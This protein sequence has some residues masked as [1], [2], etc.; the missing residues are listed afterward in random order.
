MR[1]CCPLEEAVADAWRRS[2]RT[3][4][5]IDQ[6]LVIV[7]RYRRDCAHRRGAVVE[8]LTR[9]QIRSYALR[10][11]LRPGSSRKNLVAATRSALR[12]WSIARPPTGRPHQHG[13]RSAE[14][15]RCRRMLVARATLH[16]EEHPRLE[17]THRADL[18]P[19][20]QGSSRL[21]VQRLLR[22]LPTERLRR[23]RSRGG[24]LGARRT[25]SGVGSF[26]PSQGES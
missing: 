7:R 11:A 12:A 8:R 23:R 5:S 24:G 25:R 10:R 20:E 9:A 19:T 22:P 4:A 6:Y 17:A 26:V 18:H 15:A 3:R 21:R 16:A 1:M 2:G 13:A 14:A